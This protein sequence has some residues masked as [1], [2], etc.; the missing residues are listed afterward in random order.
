MTVNFNHK[1]SAH[2]ENG[3]VSNLL[4][5]HGLEFDEPMV[6]GIGSGLFFTYLPFVR[7]NGIPGVAYR[8][9]PGQI[10]KRFSDRIGIKIERKKFSNPAKAM[11]ALDQMLDKGQPVGMLTS[12][13][14][15]DY[16]PA[17]Y[18]FHFNAHNIIVFGK[19]NGR[20]LVS[21]PVMETTTEIS[22]EDLARARFAKG[23]PEPSGRMY[24]PLQVPGEFNTE[25]ALWTGIKQTSDHMTRIPMPLVG[26]K[27]MKYLAGRMRKWPERIGDRK[28]ILWLGN[29][30]RMQEEIGTGG[31]GF[32]FIYAAFL[33]QAGQKLNN[34]KLIDLSKQL[35]KSG[36]K[37]RDFAYYAGRVCKNR[38][39]D[40]KTFAELG[41]IL[42]ECSQ[43]EQ[44]IFNELYEV[45]RSK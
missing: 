22:Y 24:Y 11:D 18:R 7:V 33:D 26:T 21:D 14:F 30:I 13:F 43:Q 37:L 6:F 8:I 23:M 5:F 41:D 35:T 28:A 44:A 12:V 4:R 9:W 1:Q 17:A 3:V 10:F 38:K 27:G 15:L 16:L 40:T 25:K 31:A 36:D 42:E 45:S 29:L 39:S 32:R 20:Y 34:D 19:E 2:C